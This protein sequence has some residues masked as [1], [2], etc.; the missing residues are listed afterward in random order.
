[1]TGTEYEKIRQDVAKKYKSEIQELKFENMRLKKM[2]LEERM[3]KE[4]AEAQLE[5]AKTKLSKLSKGDQ[6]LMDFFSLY[7]GVMNK[8]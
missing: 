3:A 2:I 4:K 6:M 5:A 7:D 1:M 8:F